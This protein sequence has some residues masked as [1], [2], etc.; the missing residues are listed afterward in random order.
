MMTARPGPPK[1]LPHGV[2][3]ETGSADSLNPQPGQDIQDIQA[4][5]PGLGEG[6]E[7]QTHETAGV[8]GCLDEIGRSTR[9]DVGEQKPIL[10]LPSRPLAALGVDFALQILRSTSQRGTRP[11]TNRTA[12]RTRVSTRLPR[13]QSQRHG[14]CRACCATEA[15]CSRNL[16]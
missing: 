11:T 5:R 3:L 1:D 16:R 8:S 10:A 12:A 13:P 7:K 6:W 15:Q 9:V 4:P 14:S 2:A